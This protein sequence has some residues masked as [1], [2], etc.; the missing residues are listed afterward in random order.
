MTKVTFIFEVNGVRTE[1]EKTYEKE[2]SQKEVENDMKDWFF[3]NHF[4]WF[5]VRKNGVE[6]NLEDIE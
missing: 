5:A 1:K 4:M 6:T 2:P 3:D